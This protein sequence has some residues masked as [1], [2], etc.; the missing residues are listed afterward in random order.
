MLGGLLSMLSAVTFAFANVTVRRG[1]LTG[2]G[3]QAVVLSIVL[4]LPLFAAALMMTNGLSALAHFSAADFVFLA[5][6]GV[7]HFAAA[8]YCNYRATKAIGT[9]LVGPTQQLSLVITLILAVVW[10]GETITPLRIVGI[11]LLVVGPMLTI[12]A[13]GKARVSE[14]LAEQPHDNS[15]MSFEPNY[16]E[17]YTFA[18]LS[19]VGFGISPILVRASFRASSISA[20]IAGGFVSYAAAAAV[21]GAL[22]LLPRQRAGMS[23]MDAGTVK[24]FTVSGVAICL[25]QM[26]R[27]VAL[28][29]APVTVVSPIQRVSLIFRYY[30]SHALNPHHEIFGGRVIVGTGISLIGAVALS[31]S[32][33]YGH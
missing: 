28:A 8:R 29:I 19:A 14:A 10:L 13:N 1:V 12:S 23:R 20:G 5:A 22:L 4:G 17:G 24:W 2:T 32:V 3:F 33:G 21:I 11:A 18:L 7:I 26:L 27:Y 9:N 25:S 30:L 15:V 16:A 6:A 31:I